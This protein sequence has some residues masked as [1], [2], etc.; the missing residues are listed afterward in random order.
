M[1]T[2]TAHSY[3]H[4]P[5]CA[6]AKHLC[7]V[8]TDLTMTVLLQQLQHTQRTSIAATAAAATAAVAAGGAL[9]AGPSFAGA[10]IVTCCHRM[11]SWED[12]PAAGKVWLAKHVGAERRHFEMMVQCTS[13]LP[14]CAPCIPHLAPPTLH[15]RKPRPLAAACHAHT[16]MPCNARQLETVESGLSYSCSCLC[17]F[18]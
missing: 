2:H 14:S 5:V 17:I 1:C 16:I 3:S 13:C 6:V 7:G 9:P 11:M 18:V 15:P 12:Y 8:A 10:A 4:R